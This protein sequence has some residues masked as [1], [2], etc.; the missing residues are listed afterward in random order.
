MPLMPN[1]VVNVV[2]LS[3]SL[4]NFI[5]CG[6]CFCCVVVIDMNGYS[7]ICYLLLWLFRQYFMFIRL[8]RTKVLWKFVNIIGLEENVT[9]IN[10]NILQALLLLVSKYWITNTTHRTIVSAL[11]FVMWYFVQN[12]EVCREMLMLGRLI[13]QL[14]IKK[15][16]RFLSK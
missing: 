3:W 8:L 9:Q 10:C 6:L 13:K 7:Q 11:C 16:S 5:K 2:S 14:F 12:S 4:L 1:G 15:N